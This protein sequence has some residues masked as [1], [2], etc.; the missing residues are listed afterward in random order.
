MT[1]LFSC[2]TRRNNSR[3]HI[4]T[5]YYLWS[6]LGSQLQAWHES[7]VANW[8]V[9]GIRGIMLYVLEKVPNQFRNPKL[10]RSVFPSFDFGVKF[11][12]VVCHHLFLPRGISPV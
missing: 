6:V 1:R 5:R 7:V 2:S 9:P 8:V 12:C 4:Q 11:I 3:R 10:P